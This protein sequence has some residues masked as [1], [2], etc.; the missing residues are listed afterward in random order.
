[1]I[2]YESDRNFRQQYFKREFDT[3]QNQATYALVKQQEGQLAW[4]AMVEGQINRWVTTTESVPRLDAWLQGVSLFDTL[5]SH[6]HASLGYRP[7]ASREVKRTERL[8]G[9]V[10]R[11]F[12]DEM[13]N[14]NG[15]AG[16]LL[17]KNKPS[18]ADLETAAGTRDHELTER[19]HANN[20]LGCE[21]FD[22][23]VQTC[24]Y[25]LEKPLIG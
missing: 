4:T 16:R 5:T 7:P 13:A 25:D 12:G 3:A 11:Q 15:W 6:T 23:A 1:M 8:Y 18:F 24:G 2:A 14:D 21:R 19:L 10:L 17:K 22:A 9:L 20:A